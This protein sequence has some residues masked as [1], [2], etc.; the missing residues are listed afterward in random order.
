MPMAMLAAFLTLD[1]LMTAPFTLE[2]FIFTEPMLAVLPLPMAMLAAFLTLDLLMT[3]PLTFESLI[4]TEPMLAVFSLP[5][6]MLAAFLTLDLLMTA[7][8]TL[9]SA[10]EIPV[11]ANTVTIVST[12]IFFMA[13][14][15]KVKI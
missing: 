7:P 3:A 5:M 15:L 13:C 10:K 2:S 9:D 1:L 14:L 6:E 11:K 4:L 12:I 8:F